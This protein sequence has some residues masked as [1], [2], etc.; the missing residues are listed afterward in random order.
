MG[1]RRLTLEETNFLIDMNVLSDNNVH[2]IIDGL[3]KHSTDDFLIF[4]IYKEKE[5]ILFDIVRCNDYMN[6]I[7]T[8]NYK[9]IKEISNMPINAIIDAYELNERKIIEI[10]DE[11][12]IVNTVLGKD[13]AEIYGYD[14][15]DGMKFILHNDKTEKYNNKIL[16]VKNVGESIRLVANRGR[17][18][19]SRNW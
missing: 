3:S 7:Y 14:L 18:R 6:K 19:K 2:L 15:E 4:K 8:I 1:E 17:P 5:N 10:D 9:Q 13:E 11:T 12:D 16:T